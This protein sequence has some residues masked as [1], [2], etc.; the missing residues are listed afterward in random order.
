MKISYEI[1]DS[2]AKSHRNETDDKSNTCHIL[3][4]DKIRSIS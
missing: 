3:L 2:V 1:E 4:S